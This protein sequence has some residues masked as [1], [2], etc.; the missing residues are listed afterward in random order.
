MIVRAPLVVVGVVEVDVDVG[1][2]TLVIV[3][4]G[5]PVAVVVAEGREVSWR[6]TFLA[7]PTLN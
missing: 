5:A 2:G 3:V 1:L 4:C 7:N 6:W